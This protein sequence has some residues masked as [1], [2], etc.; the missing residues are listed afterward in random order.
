MSSILNNEHIT[1]F[2]QDGAILIKEN[3]ITI[4]LKYLNKALRKQN[5]IQAQ[6]L[7]ITPK[8]QIHLNI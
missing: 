3:L 7:Q 1:K 2:N 6:D 8:V 5:P 4:G